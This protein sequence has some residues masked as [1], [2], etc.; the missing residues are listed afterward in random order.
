MFRRILLVL[1]SGLMDVSTL[2]MGE[3]GF[4]NMG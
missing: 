2:V 1:S 4:L 3:A